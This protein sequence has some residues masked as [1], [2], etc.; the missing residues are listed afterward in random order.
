MAEAGFDDFVVEQWQAVFAPAATPAPVIARLNADIGRALQ[1]PPLLA[2][3]EQ[4]GITLAG[5]TPQALDQIRKTDFQ[6]WGKVIR[7]A[8][9]KPA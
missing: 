1:S 9:I 6:K 4:L 2:L 7:D 5:V 3:A 8:G